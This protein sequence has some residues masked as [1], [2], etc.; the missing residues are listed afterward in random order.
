MAG[1]E[2]QCPN[3]HEVGRIVRIKAKKLAAQ[4]R[5]DDNQRQDFEQEF[6]LHYLRVRD[7]YNASR[8]RWST[9]LDRIFANR[10]HN[11]I[12]E[13]QTRKRCMERRARRFDD[14]QHDSE[15]LT[16]HDVYGQ[17]DYFRETGLGPR[18]ESEMIDTRLD[19]ERILRSLP[20]DL[21]DLAH[22][23]TYQ[24]KAEAAREL[25]IPRST[26]YGKIERIGEAFQAAGLDPKLPGKNS[27]KVARRPDS[28]RGSSGK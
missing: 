7:S 11:M 25:H 21:R 26:L 14:L 24:S 1:P 6:W 22:R 19:V 18:P 23:L 13:W 28:P 10:S 4:L 2:G 8:G 5:V 9:F 20:S 27:K 12:A 3:D 15:N 16:I 17:D